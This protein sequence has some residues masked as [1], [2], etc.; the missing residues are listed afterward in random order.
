[1]IL[2]VGTTG[3]LGGTVTRMLLAEG[4]PVCA[5]V[6]PQSNYQSL[7]DAGAQVVMGDLKHPH[8]LDA[9]CKGVETII[10]TANA[11]FRGGD[12]TPESVD[13]H[14]NRH[15]IDAAKA[16]GVKQ[17]IFV[18]TIMADHNSPIPIARAKGKTEEYL[19]TSGVPFTIIAPNAY[20]EMSLVG[21]VGMPAMQGQTVYIVGEGRRKHS[22]ISMHDVAA[23]LLAVIDDPA[24]INQKLLLGG[25]QALSFEDAVAIYKQVLGREITVAHAVPGEP[26][27]GM[28]DV[29]AQFLGGFDL[30]ESPMDSTEL[31]R[32]FGVRLTPLEEVARASSGAGVA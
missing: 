28:P 16:A 21:F 10:T 15:L 19:R 3:N 8:S 20:M 25:P 18:S 14:G 31:A 17:L 32:T 12:D 13:L 26:V 22:F 6:R 5:L 24:A 27:P 2:V 30:F 23:F 7:V 4:M 9:A 1:M 11:G 29:V